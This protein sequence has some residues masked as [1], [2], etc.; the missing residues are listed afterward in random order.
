MQKKVNKIKETIDRRKVIKMANSLQKTIKKQDKEIE[1]LLNRL[2]N[3]EEQA[4]KKAK[5]INIK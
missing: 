1:N 5:E 2:D 4:N 3:M